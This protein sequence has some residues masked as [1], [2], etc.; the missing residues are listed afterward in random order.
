[1]IVSQFSAAVAV[2]VAP[3]VAIVTTISQGQPRILLDRSFLLWTRAKPQRSDPNADSD[4]APEF[5]AL[6]RGVYV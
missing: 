3:P 4:T 2:T 6:A 5:L 1:V